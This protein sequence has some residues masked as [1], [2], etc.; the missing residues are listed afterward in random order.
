M[1]QMPQSIEVAM[2]K[3]ITN[4]VNWALLLSLFKKHQ[5]DL[6][7]KQKIKIYKKC[8]SY[9]EFWNSDREET[10]IYTNFL[11]EKKKII[12]I[13]YGLGIKPENIYDDAIYRDTDIL[14]YI[15]QKD[16]PVFQHLMN[17]LTILI[18]TVL[19]LLVFILI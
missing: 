19:L 13:K 15:Q 8:E 14:S 10:V 2:H 11:G 3:D 12:H 5:Q 18:P 7:Y 6:T 16:L 4:L 17:K 9:R 1:S